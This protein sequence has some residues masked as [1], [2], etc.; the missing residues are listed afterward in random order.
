MP[1][2]RWD[3]TPVVARARTYIFTYPIKIYFFLIRFFGTVIG[4]GRMSFT[5][6]MLCYF[7]TLISKL[8]L[9]RGL[10]GLAKQGNP[11]LSLSRRWVRSRLSVQGM[12]LIGRQTILSAPALFISVASTNP[13]WLLFSAL[14]SSTIVGS[15]WSTLI[16]CVIHLNFPVGRHR[17]DMERW[18]SGRWRVHFTCL[19][20]H[21]AKRVSDCGGFWHF[22]TQLQT[23]WLDRICSF[24]RH[25]KLFSAAFSHLLSTGRGYDV[26][27]A[28]YIA[29]RVS[30]EVLAITLGCSHRT[31]KR[32]RQ[33]FAVVSSRSRNFEATWISR[34]CRNYSTCFTPW[35]HASQNY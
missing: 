27:Y 32:T 6:F 24:S 3:V 25:I 9:P 7:L 23:S 5:S 13:T 16:C 1:G 34:Y 29:T 8:R 22:L 19:E 2:I 11:T 17:C 14:I 31:P 10:S 33:P 26:A 4:L 12:S 30:W 35:R 28:I 20:K 21:L 15:M 18:D